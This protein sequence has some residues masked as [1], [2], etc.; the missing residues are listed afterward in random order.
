MNKYAELNLYDL[1]GET[2]D[3]SKLSKIEVVDKMTLKML[4]KVNANLMSF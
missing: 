3:I 2:C 4:E 1:V